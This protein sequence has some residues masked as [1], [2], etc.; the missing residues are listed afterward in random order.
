MALPGATLQCSEGRHYMI[1]FP[2]SV[3]PY[4]DN[5]VWQFINSR[6]IDQIFFVSVSELNVAIFFSTKFGLF[7]AKRSDKKHWK[8]FGGAT[9]Q[10]KM[11]AGGDVTKVQ[12]RRYY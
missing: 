3:N 11:F 7:D 9:L 10:L 8:M 1:R 5:I 4:C 12:G 6:S 2:V